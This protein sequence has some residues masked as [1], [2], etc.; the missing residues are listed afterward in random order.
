MIKIFFILIS[1]FFLFLNLS[2]KNQIL[3]ARENSKA[4]INK[5]LSARSS[6]F[7]ANKTPD[8]NLDKQ[9]RLFIIL[10]SISSENE[11][12]ELDGEFWGHDETADEAKLYPDNK[13]EIDLLN[14]AGYIASGTTTYKGVMREVKLLPETISKDAVEKIKQCSTDATGK[15]F[16]SKVFGISPIESSRKSIKLDKI[17]SKEL[18][19]SLVKDIDSKTIKN[20]EGK[21][22]FDIKKTKGDLSLTED[23]WTDL[24]GDGEI[25]L[26]EFHN[27]PC[28][29]EKETCT[30]LFQLINGK[31]KEIN[32]ISPI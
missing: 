14:C 7:T 4:E 20:R 22:V 2:C 18:Y 30:W 8:K 29:D 19:T 6:D 15:I 23:N 3:S 12:I 10:G 25:D 5:E 17:N 13:V 24:D 9:K 28:E 16:S 21:I 1:L 11:K 32:Y 31:W 26:V 27:T